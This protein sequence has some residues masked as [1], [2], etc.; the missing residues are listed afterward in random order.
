LIFKRAF[1]GAVVLAAAATATAYAQ[2]HEQRIE[3]SALAG[4]T[5][6][7]GVTGSPVL[8][9]DGNIYD[10]IDPRSSFSFSLA[11]G[12]YVT[13]SVLVEGMWSRQYSSLDLNGTNNRGLGSFNIDNVHALVAY[14]F[15]EAN[16]PIRPYLG[17]GLGWTNYGTL[18]I[19]AGG[20]SRSING[21]ARFSTKWEAG[22]KARASHNLAVRAGVTFTPTYVKSDASGWWCDPFWGCY[23][24]GNA[25]YSNQWDFHGGLSF[26]F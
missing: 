9:G 14:H 10:S 25:Q 8:A 12:Y 7:D 24:T 11:G 16:A 22:V 13:P 5:A 4:Y 2:E 26:R 17:G 1:I 3:L 23:V 18:D 20:V 19:T 15:L 21:Q 6:S